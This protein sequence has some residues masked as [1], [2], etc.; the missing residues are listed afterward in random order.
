[1]VEGEQRLLG[2]VGVGGLRIVDEDRVAEPRD[3]LHPVVKTRK[4]AQ[5]VADL[6]VGQ[7]Q[8]FANGESSRCVLSV[9]LAP[10]SPHGR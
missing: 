4:G 10:Q 8:K 5:A 9:V 6:I 7:S 2:R 1:M 3:L